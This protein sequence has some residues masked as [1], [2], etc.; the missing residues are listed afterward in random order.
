[1]D[2]REF[3]DQISEDLKKVLPD[4][5]QGV[6]ITARQ[7]DK[8]QG[9]SYYGITVQPENSNIGISMDLSSAFEAMENGRSYD[10]VLA[11]LGTAVADG[12]SN[13]PNVRA[14]E[15]MDYEAMKDKL[16]VQVVPTAGNEEMLAGIPHVEQEDMSL[17]YRF[18]IE[19]NEQGSATTLV[20]NQMLE[21]YG[22]S[23][24]QLHAD[25][26]ANA[27]EQFPASVRS[28]QEVLAEIMG[29]EP[30]MMPGEP[31]GMYVATCNQGVNGA[32]CIFYPEFMDQAAEKLGGDFFVLPSSVHEVILLPDTGD[33]SFHELESMVQEI[34]ATEVQP[35][36]RL[37]DSVYHYDAEEHIFEKAQAHDERMQAKKAEREGSHEKKSIMDKLAEKKKEAQAISSDKHAPAKATE[38][39]L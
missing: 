1:M 24:E 19:T 23:A 27:P 32:G 4:E 22:I 26:M 28:M 36:D 12:F 14:A 29:I 37:S 2:Y 38:H 6:K 3:V 35:A 18:V 8:L 31:G 34:N 33:M 39:S 30:E 15:L 21:N 25:A 7:V 5:L 16:M 11:E 17:V 9:A 13:R 10:V 20:T